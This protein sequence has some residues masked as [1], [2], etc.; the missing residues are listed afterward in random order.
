MAEEKAAMQTEASGI[1][2]QQS[3]GAMLRR[4]AGRM[5]DKIALIFDEEC[6]TYRTLDE[7]ADRIARGLLAAGVARGDRVAVIARN[8]HWFVGLRFGVARAGAILVPINFMLTA[9]EVAFILTNSGA[10]LLFADQACIG[11]ATDAVDLATASRIMPLPDVGSCPPGEDGLTQLIAAGEKSLAALPSIN[12]R[13]PAQIL[14]TSG[15]ESRPKGAVLTHEAILWQVQG[16]VYG[17]DWNSQAVVI[18]ALPLFHC[19]QLDGF[20]APGLSVGATSVILD[21]PAP[22]KIIAAVCQHRATSLFCPPTIWIDLLRRGEGDEDAMATLTHGYYGASIMPVE[23]LRELGE[24][25]PGLRLWN[26]YGQTETACIATLL[27]PEDQVRKIGSAGRPAL[28]VETRIVDDLMQDVPPGEIGEVVHRSPQLMSHYWNDPERT[29]EAFAGG[30]F[31]SGDLATQDDEGYI[32]IVDR[33]KDMIKTGGENVSSREV[34][35]ALYA[36]PAVSEAAVIGLPD[37][38]WIEAVTAVIVPRSGHILGEAEVIMGCRTKL[39]GFKVPKRVVFL[40][41]LPRNAS[42]KIL[43][44]ELRLQLMN[45]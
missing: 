31:H 28:H 19:A 4:T 2:R 32:T 11:V 35:E 12:G 30:W 7:M 33:K 37:P 25:M 24:R 27:Q 1:A 10:V 8:S 40:D 5:P 22:D 45:S 3:L 6:W 26:C 23:V 21:S 34:E 42:G 13:D 18:N 41:S 36:M 14:Y 15:T 16:A 20:M 39:A 29:A 9:E 44:R 17:C 38:R 43:K